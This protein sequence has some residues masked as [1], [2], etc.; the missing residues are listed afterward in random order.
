[1]LERF[2]QYLIENEKSKATIE[3]YIRD[4]QTFC[5]FLGEQE[6]CKAVVLR[7]KE[8]LV[9]KYA[10]A[11][12]NSMLAALNSYLKFAGLENCCVKRLKIQRSSFCDVQKEL[13]KAEYLRLVS[14]ANKC[15]ERLCLAMQTLCSAG[16]RVSELCFVTVEAVKSCCVN[17][18]CKGKRR[19]VFLPKELCLHLLKYAEKRKI[20]SGSIFITKSGK[21]W[22]RS[23]IWSAMKRICKT[24]G[25]MAKKVF[26][27]NLRHLFARAF[28]RLEK[29]VVKL[30]DILGH[31]NI[32]T[33]RI[34]TASTGKEHRR[35]LERLHLIM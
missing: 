3:K 9:A 26:P 23:N 7:Y 14:A 25:V 30:A 29:D 18:N 10:P 4:L 34:Y 13:S 12:V 20:K 5:D 27:H 33:T 32:N 6:I 1:M 15:D 28:Y 21:A 11:S 19:L 24:A 2:K 16:M 35:Q 17:V 8:Q 31:S 22:D